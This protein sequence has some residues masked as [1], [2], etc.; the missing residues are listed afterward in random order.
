[1][2][3]YRMGLELSV[4]VNA[5]NLSFLLLPRTALREALRYRGENPAVDRSANAGGGSYQDIAPKFGISQS[6]VFT[7]MGKVVDAINNTPEVAPFFFPQIDE[8]CRFFAAG[9]EAKSTNGIFDHV[10][11]ATEGPLIKIKAPPAKITSHTVSYFSGSNTRSGF[12]VQATCD[13]NYRFCSI[14]IIAPGAA[15]D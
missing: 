5:N 6:T 10:V 7:I 8:E 12:N 14:S 2:L 9:F 13:A 1:M 15:T 4:E 3:L 11:S